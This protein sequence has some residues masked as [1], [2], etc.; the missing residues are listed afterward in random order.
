MKKCIKNSPSSAKTSLSMFCATPS[1]LFIFFKQIRK[2]H[3]NG[4]RGV[5][6]DILAT[7]FAQ[8]YTKINTII[9]LFIFVF[10]Y[11][12]YLTVS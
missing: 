10:M 8:F 1:P 9:F 5:I 12:L 3:E 6:F 7:T 4:R 11:C 2:F